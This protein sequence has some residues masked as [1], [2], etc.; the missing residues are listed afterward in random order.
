MLGFLGIGSAFNTELGNNC[1][2]F[3]RERRLYLIDCGSTTFARLLAKGLLEGIEQI[4]V[5]VTHTHADHI[6]SLGDLVFYSYFNH[7]PIIR[8][9][10]A[11]I[12]PGNLQMP[13]LLKLMGVGQEY[14]DYIE[15]SG[16]GEVDDISIDYLQVP[17]VP[18][19]PCYAYVLKLDGR[20]IYYSGD[21]VELPGSIQERFL[22]GEIDLLYQDTSS[23]D[24]PLHLSLQQLTEL[25]PEYRR[26]AV[27]CMHLD[28][29][30]VPEEAR[31]L[32]FQVVTM[33]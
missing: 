32:G 25:I 10:I 27:F 2:Y 15:L 28:H 29:R 19:L 9:K 13:E 3:V 1:A 8:K 7:P 4:R 6:G 12:A 31:G 30:F 17:H 24:H 14:Y 21:S 26:S 23:V 33:E 11:I 22:N 18:S 20:V 16:P 5:I